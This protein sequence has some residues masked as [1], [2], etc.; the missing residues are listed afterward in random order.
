M[1]PLT[2]LALAVA[3]LAA[4]CGDDRPPA[5]PEQRAVGRLLVAW[6]EA[7]HDPDAVARLPDLA[8]VDDADDLAELVARAGPEL[9]TTALEGVD[10]DRHLLVVG[11]YPRCDE[12]SQVVVA[13]GGREL[14]F[15]VRSPTADAPLVCDRSPRQ[16]DVW[17]VRRGDV[18]DDASLIGPDGG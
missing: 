6:S 16:V 10:V 8:L 1:R 2:A 18:A 11:A 13:E 12:T 3:A 15:A 17:A 7:D 14:R 4:G 9:D 5:T